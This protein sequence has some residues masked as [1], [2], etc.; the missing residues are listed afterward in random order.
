MLRGGRYGQPACRP[1]NP[2]AAD[3][4]PRRISPAGYDR[5]ETVSGGDSL[6]DVDSATAP[7]NPVSRC[8]RQPDGE[9]G[10]G[11]STLSVE[12]R[13]NERRF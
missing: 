4:L 13:I 2:V 11:F 3:P 8:R 10:T 6:D 7:E 12:I 1:G 9:I 5:G